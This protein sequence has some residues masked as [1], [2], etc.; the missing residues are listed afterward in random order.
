[1][2]ANFS[3]SVKRRTDRIQ[4]NEAFGTL[5]DT[6]VGPRRHLIAFHYRLTAALV[7]GEISAFAEQHLEEPAGC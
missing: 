2:D 1:M 3:Q 7:Q 6:W 5:P 4:Y